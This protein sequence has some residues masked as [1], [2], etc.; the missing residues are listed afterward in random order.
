MLKRI[1]KY[2]GIAFL[3]LVLLGVTFI[4]FN[5][6]N[7]LPLDYLKEKYAFEESKY[8]DLMG[9]PM[10]YV[11]QGKGKPLVLLHG[12]GGSV[13]D[14]NDW[15]NLLK[16]SFEIVRLDLP[17]FG[18]TGPN[19]VGD[20]SLDFYMAFLEQAFEVIGLDS[21][22][23][24]GNSFGG[25]LSWNYTSLH[26]EQVQRLILV[27]ASGY[28]RVSKKLP[29]AFR[30]GANPF[31]SKWLEKITPRSIIKKTALDVYADDS[32]VTDKRIDRYY[33]LL[34]REGNRKGVMQRLQQVKQDKHHLIKNIQTPTLV[35]SGDADLLVP[36]EHAHQFNKDLP[37]SVLKIYK[38]VGH[39][40][41]EEVPEESAKDVM[42]FLMNE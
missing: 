10:H 14:W 15:T 29:I 42:D 16:D 38:N 6:K 12:T 19:P 30:L 26:P 31:L 27:D 3:I 1:L 34:L 39:V 37:N 23:L 8:L 40:P 25:H 41:M 9:M 7:D 5:Y 36:V 18:L 28:P 13:R 4:A 22:Y 2:I 17:G 35:M 24:A 20:Y 11:R 33:E 32:Q 21:F